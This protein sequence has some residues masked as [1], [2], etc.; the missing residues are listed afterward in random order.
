VFISP[1]N[2]ALMG[3]APRERQ[4]TAAG[5]RA[6]AR[7]LGNMVGIAIAGAIFSSMTA[8]GA[9]GPATVF[10]AVSVGLLASCI[11]AALGTVTSALRGSVQTR[12]RER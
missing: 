1:N 2:S 8:Q 7:N 11:A 12:R 10:R 3:A 6:T 9:S 5:V 4:G